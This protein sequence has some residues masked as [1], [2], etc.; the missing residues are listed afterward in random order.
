M[1]I[2]GVMASQ[3]MAEQALAEV[4]IEGQDTKI[5]QNKKTF[6]DSIVKEFFYY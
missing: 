2:P 1:D 3:I 6:G 4:Q 5:K